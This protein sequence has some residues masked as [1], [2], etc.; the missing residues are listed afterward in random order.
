M[1][2]SAGVDS[3]S[4]PRVKSGVPPL[5]A[6][7]GISFW[8]RR[9]HSLSGIVPIGF[10]LL[11]HF[12]SNA[13]ATNGPVPYG[14]QVKFLTG[15]PFVE[16]VEAIFIW[17]PIAY[18]GFYGLYI[19]WRGEANVTYYPWSGNWLYSAQRY[20]GILA[21]LYIGW[22]TYTMRFSGL[23]L[24]GNASMAFAKVQAEMQHPYAVA[25]YV[26]GIIAAS[27]HFSYGI[28]LFCAKWGITAGERSRKWLGA[29]CF[30]LAITLI[31]VGIYTIWAFFYPAWQNEWQKLPA[32]SGALWS[33][34]Q[35][36][37]A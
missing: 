2:S 11:E 6:G 8:L 1:A 29:A 10:F 4:A 16:W 23:H 30:V 33:A 7:Q 3:P 13:F 18:H 35:T 26:V 21:F 14:D 34:V 19:W 32:E 22:H 37:F 12:V 28:W 15:I 27:W 5:Q 36:I 17:I 9:L 24:I 20:T 25:F 31:A